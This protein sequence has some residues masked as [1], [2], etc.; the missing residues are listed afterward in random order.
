MGE[1]CESGSMFPHLA[2]DS[3]VLAVT[4]ANGK[5]SSWGTYCGS[6]AK[7]N[8]KSIGSCLGDLFSVSWMED[9]DKGALAS[10]TLK[11]Q[12]TR[13][14]Q[15]TYKSHVTVFGDTSFESEPI[16]NF[17]TDVQQTKDDA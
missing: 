8:G 9:S 16:G 5:E 7:V 1:A 13:V 4:A 2:T 14:T 11:E 3:K 15:L 6:A 10:E 17:Q 12:I